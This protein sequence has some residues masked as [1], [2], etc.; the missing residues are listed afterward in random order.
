MSVR[1]RAFRDRREA[2]RALAAML[3]GLAGQP[4]VLVLGLPRG[5]VPVAFEVAAGL[6]APLDVFLVRK[7]G[8]PGHTELAMGA[9]ATGGVRVLNQAVVDSLRIP[10]EVIDEVA[11][12]EEAELARRDE[13]YRGGR[14]LPDITGRTA[15]VVD[16]GLATGATMRAALAAVRSQSPARVVA[17]APVG[18]RPTCDEL[19]R[20]A[21]EVVCVKTPVL[22]QAVGQW[23]QD[24]SPP[25]DEEIRNLLSD[26]AR[27]EP[28]AP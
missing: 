13:A 25:T 27:W 12:Q 15:V 21:D 9:I 8:V 11:R 16:D 23:Y 5:G 7:L 22:F 14:P 24:F 6:E 18:A 3:G 19:R 20:D 26:S 1:G 2:G 28:P 10:T 17:A 4:D